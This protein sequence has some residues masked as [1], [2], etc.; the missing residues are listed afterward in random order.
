[1]L[2]R[3]YRY[4][5]LPDPKL[6]AIDG[7][8]RHEIVPL[9]QAAEAAYTPDGR[10]LFFTRL[11]R[12]PSNT[13]RYQ[14]GTAEN[15]WRYD[16]GSEAMLLT[17]DWLGTS[18]DP[19]FW[20][21]RVYFLSD[22]DGVMNIYSM[23]PNGKD[24]KQHTHHHG[25]DVQW[26]SLSNGRI[27]YQCGADLWLLDLSTGPDA[28]IT[29]TLVSDFDQLRDHWVKKPLEYL[30]PIAPDGSAAVFT[31]RGEIFTLPA[32]S[33]RIVKV[34]GNSGTR[35]R[36]ARYMADG[37]SI[38][39]VSTESEETELW[40]FPAN[41]V[42]VP[43]QWTH[44]AKVL[45]W[46]G[47]PSPDGRWLANRDK[48]Q[49]LWLY[50]TKTKR[51]KVIAQSMVEDFGDLTWS[52]D[53]QWLAYAET[54]TNTFWQIK[55]LNTNTGAIHVL[56]SDHYNSFSPSW[57]VDGKWLYF[58]SDRMLKTAVPA[59]WGSRQPDPYFDRSMKIYELALTPGVRSPFA[60]V[61]ELHPAPPEP[62]P[63]EPKADEPKPDKPTETT[64]DKPGAAKPD[65]TAAK[66]AASVML[67][68][69]SSSP[70]SPP[71]SMRC[72]CLRA[73]TPISR[74]LKSGSAGW[75]ATRAQSAC[76]KNRPRINT[77]SGD[78]P[79]LSDRMTALTGSE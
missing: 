56:T 39:A 51:Q 15:I 47:V 57:S 21:G 76:G 61:D 2:V 22:R 54:A 74:L 68:W 77:I 36:E 1:V 43:E 66:K 24:L 79:S 17:G 9:S 73:T 60:P 65:Q 62:K 20:D 10:T 53:S 26:A 63:G 7:S 55:V 4:S 33:G 59:P 46:E 45:R 11:E 34:A 38:V 49:Q 70:I 30:S 32:K 50:D 44:D 5:T 72:R 16:A 78:R 52:P 14:G 31:T 48:D 3:S 37:K 12:Q 67:R 69:T 23:D 71:G 58:L 35:Y 40:K 13:K 75:I 6:V 8:G 27:A 29:I 19:M 25:F 18:H 42:G 64:P 41:G 28:V